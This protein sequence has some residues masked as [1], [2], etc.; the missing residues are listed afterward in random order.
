[1]PRPTIAAAAALLTALTVAATTA[2]AH[3]DRPSSGRTTLR[4]ADGT[5]IG[6]AFEMSATPPK[7]ACR[8]PCRPVRR[9]SAPFTGSTSTP[10]TTLPTAAGA[11]PTRLRHPPRASSPRTAT[12]HVPA[13]VTVTT[14]ATYPAC[15]STGTAARPPRS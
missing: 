12:S 3:E 14:P 9:R 11:K 10:M 4:L 13:S 1:M 6:D 5:A 2:M 15:I 7:C 8:S